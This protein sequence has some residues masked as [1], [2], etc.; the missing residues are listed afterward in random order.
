MFINYL[1]FFFLINLVL[2]SWPFGEH[3]PVLEGLLKARLR[4]QH[5]YYERT[6]NMLAFHEIWTVVGRGHMESQ[7]VA[8]EDEEEGSGD[9]SLITIK[10]K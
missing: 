10:I 6:E 9:G 3:V 5:A 8:S 1:I 2:P 4:V 7:Q